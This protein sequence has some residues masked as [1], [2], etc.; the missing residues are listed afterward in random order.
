M[1]TNGCYNDSITIPDNILFQGTVD[2]LVNWVFPD[3]ESYNQ[4]EE[5]SG[6]RMCERAILTPKNEHVNRINNLMMDRFPADGNEFFAQSADSLTQEFE[7]AGI[8]NEYLNT[9]NPPGFPPHRLRLK[10]GMP[11]I[12]LR[13]LNPSQGL[14]NGSKLRLQKIH[15]HMIEVKIIGGDHDGNIVCL[16]RILLKPT[17][18]D[19]P[20]EWTRRQFPVNIAFAITINKSQGQTL[21]KVAIYLP[22]PCFAHGQLYTALSRVSHPKNIRVMIVPS[23]DS[24]SHNQTRNIV[25]TE[26]L[27][28]NNNAAV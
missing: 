13:N 16:P 17:D 15:D 24:P 20:F 26:I 4:V 6:D 8:P 18:G 9:I 27:G 21:S 23:D 7:N 14:S 11:L 28:R 12:L 1:T 10:I 19:Y 22:E 3:I 25:Y 2:G 5:D